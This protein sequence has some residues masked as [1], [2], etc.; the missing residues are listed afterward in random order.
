MKS[1]MAL[2]HL[3][4]AGLGWNASVGDCV[5]PDESDDE[6]SVGG[7]IAEAYYP[8]DNEEVDDEV[9][10][11]EETDDD[12]AG[13]GG[14]GGLPHGLHEVDRL[15]GPSGVMSLAHAGSDASG[16]L[17]QSHRPWPLAH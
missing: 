9:Y 15:R 12:V 7:E 16:L 14:G 11:P 13:G 17:P 1:K 8:S 3:L 4:G 2:P 5:L 6:G 10:P